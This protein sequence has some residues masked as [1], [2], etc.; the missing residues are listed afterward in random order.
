MSPSL[1]V[2]D[3]LRMCVYT[4]GRC[5]RAQEVCRTHAHF[6]RVD[7]VELMSSSAPAG[8]ITRSSL[9]SDHPGPGLLLICVAQRPNGQCSLCVGVCVWGGGGGVPYHR[10][11]KESDADV[12]IYI[13]PCSVWVAMFKIHPTCAVRGTLSAQV[14]KPKQSLSRVLKLKL[15]ASVFKCVCWNWCQF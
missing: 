5:T 10:P 7:C 14:D 9:L 13:G 1:N 12:F 4:C 8:V 11:I 2:C 3:S 15:G 6:P